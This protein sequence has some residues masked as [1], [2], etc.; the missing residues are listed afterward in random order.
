MKLINISIIKN[1]SREYSKISISNGI[2]SKKA[3]L[4]GTYI[5]IKTRQVTNNPLQIT[6]NFELGRII[7]YIY[8]YIYLPEKVF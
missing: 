4:M 1:P 3:I 6:L 8:I 5:A 7:H 2:L